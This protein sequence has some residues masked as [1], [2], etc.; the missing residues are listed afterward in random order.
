MPSTSRR[1]YLRGLGGVGAAVTFGGC[2]T[3]KTTYSFVAFEIEESLLRR[4]TWRP[5]AQFPDRVRSLVDSLEPGGSIT[6][7]DLTLAGNYVAPDRSRRAIPAFV[8][9]DGTYYNL[10]LTDERSVTN[11]RWVFWFDELG[12][13]ATADGKTVESVPDDLSETDTEIFEE[14]KMAVTGE[15]GPRD[16]DDEPPGR[17]GFVYRLVSPEA[18]A[19]VPDPPFDYYRHTVG[20]ETLFAARAKEYEIEETEYEYTLRQIADSREEL[21]QYVQSEIITGSLGVDG[22]SKQSRTIV[23][24]SI[25]E[26]LPHRESGSPSKAFSAVL[27]RLGLDG[28]SPPDESGESVDRMTYFTYDGGY[29]RGSLTVRRE[30]GLF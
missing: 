23:R 8:E 17:R 6:T 21:N 7:H 13:D 10:E 5:P 4:F 2:V 22:L 30:S 12:D 16:R 15:F 29:Y 28:V 9:R 14:A 11:D 1:R 20:E 26:E 25:E 3:G 24:E 18:S 27:A 19:L